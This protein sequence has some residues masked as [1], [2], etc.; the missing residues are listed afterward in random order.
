M[1]I[2]APHTAHL[3]GVPGQWSDTINPTNEGLIC[4][5]TPAVVTQDLAVAP[6]QTIPAYTPVGFNGSNQLIPAVSGTTQAIGIILKDVVT[7]AGQSPGVPVLRAGCV[8]MDVVAW[9][10][11]YDTDTKKLNAF[12]GAPTPTNFVVRVARKGSAVTLP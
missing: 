6:S 8:R 10:A 3:A 2:N 11:S 7:A 12:A 5:E 1:A 4:G 9:P